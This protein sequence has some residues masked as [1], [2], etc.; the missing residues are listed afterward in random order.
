MSQI[1]KW[2]IMFSHTA[3]KELRKLDPASV[4]RIINFFETK[5]KYAENPSLFAKPLTGHLHQ[6]WRF[7]IEDYRAICDIQQ[8]CLIVYVLHVG[9]RRHVYK[10]HV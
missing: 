10:S 3:Q 7:R 4:R 2:N 6:F 5:I 9:H 1:V 8:G